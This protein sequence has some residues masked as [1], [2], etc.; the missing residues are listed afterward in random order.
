MLSR[1]LARGPASSAPS[2]AAAA[3]AADGK[4]EGKAEVKTDV[5]EAE[6]E[7][8]LHLAHRKLSWPAF[9]ALS[10]SS[11]GVIFGDIATSPLYVYVNVFQDL[12]GLGPPSRVDVL[13]AAS[14]VF[15]T[16]SLIVLVKYIGV[17]LRADDQG[18]GGTFA[19]YSLLC[20]NMGIRPHGS[21]GAHTGPMPTTMSGRPDDGGAAGGG[22]AGSG[23][24]DNRQPDT[25]A[26]AAVTA[27]AGEAGKGAVATRPFPAGADMSFDADGREYGKEYGG[28]Y[29]GGSPPPRVWW[30]RWAVDKRAVGGVFRRSRRLQVGGGEAGGQ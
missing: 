6:D 18:Q 9:A 20:R 19:L 5:Q 30:Q 22:A 16:L 8:P 26:A 28:K 23:G 4:A 12:S 21:R 11:I 27:A 17:V 13:G 10:W 15:W 24:G 3:A 2:P 25:T 7:L 29:G 1:R 14:L